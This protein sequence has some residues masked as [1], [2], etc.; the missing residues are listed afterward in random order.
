MDSL[1]PIESLLP[2]RTPLRW[3]D[4]LIACDAHTA[5]A[6]VRFPPG[7]FATCNQ[8]LLEIALVESV[9]Q[10]VG[11]ANAWRRRMPGSQTTPENR[12]LGML[13]AIG[14]FEILEPLPEGATL[15]IEVRNGKRLGSLLR[16]TGEVFFEN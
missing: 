5:T 8:G 1:A 4:A 3:I 15:R 9:A 16:V 2:H 13:A 11:A 12:G 7:H 10:T 14:G 6:A